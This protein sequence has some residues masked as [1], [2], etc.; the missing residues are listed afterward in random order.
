M[1]RTRITFA[2]CVV[3][4]VAL[5]PALTRGSAP[6]AT[7]KS[8]GALTTITADQLEQ[9]GV[10]LEPIN[11]APNITEAEA[12]KIAAGRS[13]KH[14]AGPCLSNRRQVLCRCFADPILNT[15]KSIR[16]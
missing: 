13:S 15:P 5:L 14:L 6:A 11:A 10:R 9:V 2:L 3:V 16:C 7:V 4:V 8:S 1:T 12:S